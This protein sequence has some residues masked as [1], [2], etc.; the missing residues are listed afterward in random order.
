[1][2]GKMT[3][4]GTNF[5]KLIARTHLKGLIDEC[6]IHIDDDGYGSVQAVDM[7]NSVLCSAKV[8]LE[9]ENK[10]QMEFGL[11]RMAVLHKF[12]AGA[13]NVMCEFKETKESDTQVVFRKKGKG[14]LT[15]LTLSPGA[16]P[17]ALE[18]DVVFDQLVDNMAFKIQADHNSIRQ[19]SEYVGLTSAES[20]VFR[21]SEKK[22]ITVSNSKYSEMH[23]NLPIKVSN[24]EE[25]QKKLDLPFEVEVH[26]NILTVID[27]AQE[28]YVTDPPALFL[29][30]G[31]PVLVHLNDDNFWALSPIE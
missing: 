9:T 30:S 15:C 1:M 8:D 24:A 22:K 20:V 2:K 7:G 14:S 19:L 12:F 26:K 3:I 16:V 25:L 28:T 31:S 17:T 11:S 18:S 4:N 10:E 27:V 21:V 29:G 13:D 23:F 6:L 5:H